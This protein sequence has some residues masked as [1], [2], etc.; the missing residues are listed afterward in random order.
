VGPDD[1]TRYTIVLVSPEGARTVFYEGI[2][3]SAGQAKTFAY[4]ASDGT[5][6]LAPEAD[7]EP[8]SR[9]GHRSYR[10]TL[11]RGYLCTPRALPYAASRLP[12]RL[13]L[14]PPPGL[15]SLEGY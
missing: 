6:R 3:C 15:R 1:V 5:F 14:R 4:G 2:R 10:F 9:D 13:G 8:I 7:W 11:A 12:P